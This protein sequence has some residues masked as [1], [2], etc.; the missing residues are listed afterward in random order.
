M[1]AS[2]DYID[3]LRLRKDESKI[4][5]TDLSVSTGD[6]NHDSHQEQLGS[7][8]SPTIYYRLNNHF[9]FQLQSLITLKLI[10][11]TH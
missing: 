8:H 6:V 9:T 10:S 1:A 4:Q 11:T 7:F 5:I 2:S 3:L